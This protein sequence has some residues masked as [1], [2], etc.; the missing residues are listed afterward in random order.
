MRLP[1]MTV[2]SENE[3]E[4]E[5]ELAVDNLISDADYVKLKRTF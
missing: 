4:L 5:I 3:S 1:E 2:L